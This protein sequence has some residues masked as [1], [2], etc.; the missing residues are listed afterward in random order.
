ML[1]TCRVTG[2]DASGYLDPEHPL[3]QGLRATVEDLAGEPVAAVGVDGCGAP[4][5]AFSLVG[6]ARAIARI[7]AAPEGPERAV[8][9][10]MRARPDLVGGTQRLVTR[11]MET[12]P[13]LV[14]KDGAEGVFGAAL[15]DG[16]AVAVKIDDG[17]HRAAGAA[18][19]AG[20]RHL[21]V[22]PGV[23]ED[24]VLGGG[25]PVGTVR[26]R[27]GLLHD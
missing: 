3:Q 15:P 12:V 10:A 2:W 17:A 16:S 22:A 19:V 18:I 26:F 1:L 9:D 24:P 7:A 5:F 27:E 21:G 8:G 11:L 25:V 23:A 20:L 6:V 14:A 4:L 13:G